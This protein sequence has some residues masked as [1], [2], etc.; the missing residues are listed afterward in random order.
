MFW[1][2]KPSKIT[3]VLLVA[4][5]VHSLVSSFKLKNLRRYLMLE[6]SGV[7]AALRSGNFKKL[8]SEM[9]YSP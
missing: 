9:G 6:D 2:F 4:Y 1:K 3:T 8:V 7:S 5:T